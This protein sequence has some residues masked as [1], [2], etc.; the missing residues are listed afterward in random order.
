MEDEVHIIELESFSKLSIVDFSFVG[1]NPVAI[2]IR[3][4]S[5]I[6]QRLLIYSEPLS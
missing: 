1:K 6:V 5:K 2:D 4:I 3:K